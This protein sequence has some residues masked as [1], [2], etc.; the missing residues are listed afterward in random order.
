M[1]GDCHENH[2]C[3]TYC[4]KPPLQNNARKFDEGF[5]SLG[6]SH[7]RKSSAQT[8]CCVKCFKCEVF[9]ESLSKRLLRWSEKDIRNHPARRPSNAV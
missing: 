9:D 7:G 3:S 2:A 1:T 6:K 5:S 4:E 8:Q